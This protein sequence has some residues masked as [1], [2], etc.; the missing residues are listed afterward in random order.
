MGVGS[1]IGCLIVFLLVKNGVVVVVNDLNVEYV[2]VVV[3]EIC[4]VGG[5]VEVLVGDVIDVIWIVFFVEF[6]NI[7][8]LLCIGVN[9]VGIGGVSVFIVEYEDD[10]WDKVIVINFN[11]VFCNMKV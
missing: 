1:G 2:N 8:V 5:I 6:V 9:N 11:V 4:V 3:E 7:F 10:V